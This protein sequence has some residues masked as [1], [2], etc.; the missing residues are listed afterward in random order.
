VPAPPQVTDLGIREVK[1]RSSITLMKQSLLTVMKAYIMRN[2]RTAFNWQAVGNNS[3]V[4]IGLLVRVARFL[5]G[6]MSSSIV[7]LIVA[8]C[9]YCYHIRSHCGIKGLAMRLKVSAMAIMKLVSGSPMSDT[10]PLGVGIGLQGVFPLGFQFR[11]D[12]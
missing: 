4:G 11:Y 3:H 8:F 12:I 5:T 10:R 6:G 1:G 7:L 2:S 9:R